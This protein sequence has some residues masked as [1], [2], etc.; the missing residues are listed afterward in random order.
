MDYIILKLFKI[1][2]SLLGTNCDNIR[3]KL[4]LPPIFS[5]SAYNFDQRKY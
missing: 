2:I 1:K 4:N 5:P 3:F